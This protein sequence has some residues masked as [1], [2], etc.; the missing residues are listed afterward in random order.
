MHKDKTYL[1][2]KIDKLVGLS[3]KYIPLNFSPLAGA[4]DVQ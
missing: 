1:H 3:I 2:W 4:G